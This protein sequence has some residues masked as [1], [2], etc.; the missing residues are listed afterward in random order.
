MWG[1]AK[2]C[3]RIPGCTYTNNAYDKIL[4]PANR[5]VQEYKRVYGEGKKGGLR[6]MEEFHWSPCSEAN[7]HIFFSLFN[8]SIF[9]SNSYIVAILDPLYV[10]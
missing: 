10:V 7:A 5:K 4:N 8:S 2:A 3:T 9:M 6:H 1:K